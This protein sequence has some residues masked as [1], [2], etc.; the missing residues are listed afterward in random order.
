MR[1]ITA[2]AQGETPTPIE[3]CFERL[4]DVEGYPS[5]YPTGVKRAEQLERAPDGQLTKVAATLAL[6]SGPIQ[7]DFALEFAVTTER[8]TL[9]E[10]R[11]VPQGSGGGADLVLITWRLRALAAELTELAVAFDAE[12]DVPRFLPLGGI[13]DGIAGGFLAAA[14]ASFA[15]G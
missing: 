2:T 15:A 11:R 9:I 10:L 4:V 13:A 14:I 8:P 5:W 12:L 6:T 1:E 3:R 7:R